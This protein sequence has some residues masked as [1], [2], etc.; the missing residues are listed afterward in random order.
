MLLVV[1]DQY[2]KYL[3]VTHMTLGQ[4]IPVFGDVVRLTYIRNAGM[5][6][7]VQVGHQGLFTALSL[8]VVALIAWSLW[9]VRH[10][11]LQYWLPLSLIFGGAIGNIVDRI[12]YGNVV[13]FADVDIPDIR[14]PSWDLGW[15]TTPSLE[16]LRWPVFNV[17][18]SAITVGM[19]LLLTV[20]FLG[21]GEW[22]PGVGAGAADAQPSEDPAA[23]EPPPTAEGR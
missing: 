17:A 16:L 1:L 19:V 8:A 12:R 3:T 7:G 5:A 6:F 10:T 14:I 13:D 15:W 20:S 4:S 18:D 2:T 21:S 9:Q 11:A 23:P 22:P